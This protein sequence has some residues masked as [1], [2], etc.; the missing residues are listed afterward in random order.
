M[1]RV[2]DYGEI[3]A[4]IRSRAKTFPYIIAVDGAI[5]SGKSY[6]GEKLKKALTPGALL[7]TMDLFVSVPRSEWERKVEAGKIN[8]R[9]WYDIKRAREILLSIKSDKGLVC[10]DLYDVETGTMC[11]CLTIEAGSCEYVVLEGLFSL[12]EELRGLVDLGIFMDTPPD[13]ALTRAEARDETRRH[14]DPHGWLE[15][16]EIYYDGYLP[17][18]EEHRKN[19]DLILGG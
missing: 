1:I 3:V 6:L 16:K 14:L 7:I 12:D 15:K 13:V 5:G 18:I 4:E 19:A 11:G 10:G 8:L 17:Y 2:E 9:D